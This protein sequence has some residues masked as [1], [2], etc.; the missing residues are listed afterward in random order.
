LAVEVLLLPA[1]ESRLMATK[2]SKCCDLFDGNPDGVLNLRICRTSERCLQFGSFLS[3]D[4]RKKPNV[5]WGNRFKLFR[6]SL[7]QLFGRRGQWPQFSAMTVE[8]LP[9]HPLIDQ[10]PHFLHDIKIQ[11]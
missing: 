1:L 10:L 5:G 6:P 7:G 11:R 4:W 9:Q 3:F 8:Q 2:L